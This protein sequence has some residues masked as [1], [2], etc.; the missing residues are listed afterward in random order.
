MQAIP[1]SRKP[2]ATVMVVDVHPLIRAGF[3]RMLEG[4]SDLELCGEADG[5]SQ[6]MRAFQQRTA[7]IVTSD[8]SLS[9]GSG[10]ELTREIQTRRPE[11]RVL[12]C[13][14][15]DDTLYAERALRAGAQGYINK[16]EPAERLLTA[17]RRVLDGRVYLSDRMTERMLC[18]TVGNGE[19]AG[20]SPLNSLSDR[21]LEVFELVGHGVTTR[22]VAEHLHLSPKTIETYRENIKTKLN[23]KNATELTRHAV[24]WVLENQ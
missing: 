14:T 16:Q 8:I 7:D 19:S 2:A 15:H 5:Q 24:Q 9:D 12:I 6:A 23:L 17:I 22:Q 21:E 11:T 13:S 4:A 10:L 1:K 3:R 20:Q 18:R